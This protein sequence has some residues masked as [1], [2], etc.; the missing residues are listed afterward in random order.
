M[1][2]FV[3]RKRRRTETEDKKPP[4]IGDGESTDLKL[5]LLASLHP[6][7]ELDSDTLL[8]ALLAS[9]GSVE[10]ASVLLADQARRGLKR[11]R[12][13]STPLDRQ[14][15]LADFQIGELGDATK[16]AKL[17]TKKGITLHLFHPKDVEEHTPCTII[18]NFLPTEEADALLK[19]VLGEAP[20][21]EK[22]KFKLFD[23]VVESPHTMG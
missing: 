23:R 3:V 19:E 13:S 2:S 9:D 1:D 15:S 17:L 4:A 6:D 22:Q 20:T 21:F 5:T 16:T 11:K 7:L 10:T 14:G 8:E 12:F 18:H